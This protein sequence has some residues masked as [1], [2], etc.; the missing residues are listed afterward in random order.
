MPRKTVDT[1]TV[2]SPRKAGRQ[3][4]LVDRPSTPPPRN[5]IELGAIEDLCILNEEGEAD[6]ALAAFGTRGA[7]AYPP[8][9]GAHAQARHPHAQHAAPGRDGHVRAG[10]RPGSDADRSDVSADA[11]I[12]SRRRTA[13]S[14]PQSARL[15]DRASCCCGTD[16][17]KASA[18][19]GRQRSAVL[20]RDRLAH[21]AGRGH[22]TGHS[23][24]TT[25]TVVLANFGDGAISQGA[26]NEASTSRR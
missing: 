12:G 14:A 10:L 15:A 17:S 11:T 7:A 19:R 4:R 26:V 9:D 8:R 24:A 22:G 13:P 16:S 1:H 23:I 25:M 5:A 21:P 18:A 2:E 3:E 20:D 6:D